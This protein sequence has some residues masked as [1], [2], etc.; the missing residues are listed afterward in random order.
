MRSDID[1]LAVVM[2]V[3]FFDQL[4]GDQ[5]IVTYGRACPYV[6]LTLATVGIVLPNVYNER[7]FCG[8][9]NVR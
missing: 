2:R 5:L 6:A 1:V 9:K 4:I 3:I 7:F 8:A